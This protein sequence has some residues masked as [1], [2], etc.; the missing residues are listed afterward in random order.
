MEYAVQSWRPWTETDKELLEKVQ[1][2]AI[3]MVSGLKGKTY[4]DRLKELGLTTLEARRER[5]DMIEVYK[6]LTGKEDVDPKAWFTLA[7][8]GR[9]AAETRIS[10]GFLNLV[11]P[12]MVKALKLRENFFSVRVVDP[13]NALP[14]V[15]KKAET[16]NTFKIRYDKFI[17]GQV[18]NNK[19][20]PT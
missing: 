15:V 1:R 20:E 6:I 13:W 9:R 2:R 17:S 5:G 16:V 12:T 19:D 18:I 10:T 11:K 14:D 7:Q 3:R 8:E 4:E